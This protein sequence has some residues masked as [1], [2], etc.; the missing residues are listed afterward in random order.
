MLPCPTQMMSLT[1]IA[2]GILDYSSLQQLLHTNSKSLLGLHIV[3]D[4]LYYVDTYDPYRKTNNYVY[5][6]YKIPPCPQCS[7]PYPE[8]PYCAVCLIEAEEEDRQRIS[9][10]QC[11][12]L[13]SPSKRLHQL[14]RLAKLRNLSHWIPVFGLWLESKRL[15][16]RN[17]NHKYRYY[18][19][20]VW[21]CL[22]ATLLWYTM[23][24]IFSWGS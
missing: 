16:L 9:E 24:L 8:F 3:N 20:L 14:R 17:V 12:N 18:G 10:R 21:H 4:S 5:R 23:T 6:Q 15:Y 22:T 19:S 7:R 2:F 1:E 11:A 13:T